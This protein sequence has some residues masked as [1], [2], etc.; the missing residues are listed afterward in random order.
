MVKLALPYFGT[1]APGTVIPLRDDAPLL[2]DGRRVGDLRAARVAPSGTFLH[3]DA[4]VS[5]PD[6][7]AR[8]AGTLGHGFSIDDTSPPKD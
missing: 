7:A 1:S 3:V 2:E 6:V 5:D 4:E 8:L